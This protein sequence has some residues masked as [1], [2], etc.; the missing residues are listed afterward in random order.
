MFGLKQGRWV[1]GGKCGV[2]VGV[3]WWVK[4]HE[5]EAWRETINL[6]WGKC[7]VVR[8]GSVVVRVLW[9]ATSMWVCGVSVGVPVG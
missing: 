8:S 6:V 4:G 5:L 9:I 7:S 2:A 1:W 3:L